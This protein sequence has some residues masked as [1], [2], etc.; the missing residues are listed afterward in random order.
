M[1]GKPKKQHGKY[2]S[3]VYKPIGN[4]K[5]QQIRFP[6]NTNEKR[7]ADMRWFEVKKYEAQIKEYGKDFKLSWQTEKGKPELVEYAIAEAVSDYIRFKQSEGL[8]DLTIERIEIALNHL[9]SITGGILPVNELSINHIDLFKQHYKNNI[10]TATTININID[11]IKTFLKW[12]YVRGKIGNKLQISKL[13]VAKSLPKYIT[14]G[15]WKQIMQ[16]EKVFR[17][18]YGFEKAQKKQLGYYNQIAEHWKRAFYFFRETGCRLIEPFI[19]NLEG[20]WLIIDAN[21]S[22]T[23]IVREIY[24]DD[25]LI[26]I[27]NEMMDRFNKSKG[28]NPRSF[29]QSYSRKFKYACD[30]IGIDKHFHCMRHTYAVRRYLETRDIYIV[31]EELGHASV[32]TTEIYTKFKLSKLEQDFP[33][34]FAGCKMSEKT[35]NHTESYTNHRTQID[36][37]RGVIVGQG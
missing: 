13:R 7:T 30:T 26:E 8:K 18:Y 6:L 17:K 15:E 21:K 10:H 31:K 24:I 4:G 33:R 22:K 20:N 37:E 3:R 14:D 27:Y 9:V 2:Y 1:A 16:L 5:Y 19:G 25:P 12:L 35:N 32:T 23:G 34:K 29:S 11:K 28:K 36:Y